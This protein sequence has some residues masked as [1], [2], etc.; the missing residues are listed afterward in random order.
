[1]VCTCYSNEPS[2]Q[3][4]INHHSEPYNDQ[5]VQQLMFITSRFEALDAVVKAQS[6]GARFT[7]NPYTSSK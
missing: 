7:V 4:V 2:P 1:M 5:I 6:S 3:L